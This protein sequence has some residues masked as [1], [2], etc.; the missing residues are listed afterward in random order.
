MGVDTIA[1]GANLPRGATLYVDDNGL[2]IS[3]NPCFAFN[4]KD[5]EVGE[6]QDMFAGNGVLL[7]YDEENDENK[8]C[9]YSLM[10]VAEMVG[11]T[12]KITR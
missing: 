1:V 11:W 6:Y 3:G 2:C 8:D 9:P 5:L 4:P 10:E 12:N 7:G